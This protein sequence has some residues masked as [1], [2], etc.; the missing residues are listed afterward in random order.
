MALLPYNCRHEGALRQLLTLRS[1]RD[2]CTSPV[3]IRRSGP[4]ARIPSQFVIASFGRGI[5]SART[6]TRLCASP[7]ASRAP[8]ADGPG[9]RRRRRNVADTAECRAAAPAGRRGLRRRTTGA[10]EGQPREYQTRVRRWRRSW[11]ACV[12]GGCH[13]GDSDAHPDALSQRPS[14]EHGSEPRP[15]TGWSR[16]ALFVSARRRC[17]GSAIR[18]AGRREGTRGGRAGR[19][20]RHRSLGM[21]A[22]TRQN[23]SVSST[24]RAAPPIRRPARAPAACPP[25]VSRHRPKR[26]SPARRSASHSRHDGPDGH[27]ARARAV[28]GERPSGAAYTE[29]AS[30]M[31]E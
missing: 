28:P 29:V 26:S 30:A 15:Q 6:S 20:A 16:L 8:A 25:A 17:G 31:A 4:R 11:A 13:T 27:V 21:T 1:A 3:Y 7:S 14:I 12:A 18:D 9:R 23:S 2:C 19:R 22:L 5:G 24:T 10:R